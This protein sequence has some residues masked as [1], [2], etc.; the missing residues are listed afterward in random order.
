[1]RLAAGFHRAG[2]GNRCRHAA[3]DRGSARSG[4][5]GCRSGCTV[6]LVDGSAAGGKWC[7]PA[8]LHARCDA[9]GTGA[10][11]RSALCAAATQRASGGH[12]RSRPGRRPVSRLG[13]PAV[14]AGVPAHPAPDLRAR[15]GPGARAFGRA[16]R[17]AGRGAWRKRCVDDTDVWIVLDEPCFGGSV[18]PSGFLCKDVSLHRSGRPSQCAKAGRLRR[19]CARRVPRGVPKVCGP[20]YR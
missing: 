2:R 16:G 6:Q 20:T 5:C 1:M 18:G 15:G 19:R 12:R 17:G 8:P 11:D 7:E 3:A 14:L 4:S 10:A 9:G 13:R